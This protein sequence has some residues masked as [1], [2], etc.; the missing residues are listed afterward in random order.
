MLCAVLYVSD[1]WSVT[2]RE[3][4]RLKTDA[5]ESILKQ[6]ETGGSSA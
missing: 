4:Y 6:Q 2:L 3:G 1:I 5:E